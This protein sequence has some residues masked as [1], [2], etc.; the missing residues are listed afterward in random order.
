[1]PFDSVVA[2]QERHLPVYHALCTMLEAAFFSPEP[3]P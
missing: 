3:S 1:V 2:I